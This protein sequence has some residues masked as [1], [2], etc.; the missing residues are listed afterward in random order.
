MVKAFEGIYHLTDWRIFGVLMSK[1]YTQLSLEQRYQ[2]EVL[3]RSGSKQ[4][5][6]AFLLGVHP[7][8]ISRELRRNMPVRGP[9]CRQY[10]AGYAQHK[11]QERHVE[12]S[13]QIVFDTAMKE[14]IQHFMEEE[15]WS[16]ELISMHLRKSGERMISHEWIYQW[17]W[18]CKRDK[19]RQTRPYKHLWRYL[20][21]AKRHK[22]RGN[23]KERR[24]IILDRVGI[25]NRPAIVAK[26]KRLGDIEVDFMV[27]KERKSM[28]LVMVDRATLHTRL[29]KM[30]RRDSEEA[31][32]LAIQLMRENPYPIKTLTF[33]NDLTFKKHYKIAEA[34]NADTYFTRPYTSQDKGT[35]ENRIGTLRRFF[36][37]KTDLRLIT[38]EEIQIVEDKLNNRPVRKFNYLTTNQVLRKKIALIT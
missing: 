33:D 5:D 18:E 9:G 22:K 16:P 17:I 31:A 36:P 13:K 2:I 6:V 15:R 35:V 28:L 12:K 30:I 19:N 25:E 27:G 1:N 34:L 10:R 24:G 26:R 21:H 14:R 7:S 23:L 20:R 38:D 37:K 11:A 4:K 3:L 32:E 29:R 8:T